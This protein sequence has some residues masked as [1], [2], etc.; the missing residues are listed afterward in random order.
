MRFLWSCSQ[1][2]S[3]IV[4]LIGRAC[5]WLAFFLMFTIVSDVTLRHWFVIGS[6]AL[7]ELEWH[8]HGALFLM[9]LG[10]AYTKDS[11]VR[12]ELFSLKATKRTRAWIELI[13]GLIFL[14]PY[15]AV[16]LYFTWDYVALSW[17]YGE[18]S[19]SP[20]GLP[21]RYVIKAI[22]GLGFFVLFLAG[23]ARISEALIYL[24]APPALANQTRY[25]QG[26]QEIGHA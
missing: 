23:L 8:L 9:T 1:N 4:A 16:L 24:L 22:M 13:G 5:S 2:L 14:I 18:S 19:A 6:T 21:M 7:Q 10:W 17:A 26:R 20:T 11:H 12:I 25:A 15:V 3:S